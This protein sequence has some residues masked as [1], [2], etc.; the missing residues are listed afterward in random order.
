MTV[1]ELSRCY[2][3]CVIVDNMTD[4]PALP[5]D[6]TRAQLIDVAA[7]LLAEGGA[8]AVTTRAVAEAA[9]TQAPTIYRLF[10][11]KVGLLEA[12]VADGFARYVSDKRVDPDDDPVEGLR[13]G[14]DLHVGFGLANPELFRLMYIGLRSSAGRESLEAGRRVLQERV[15]RIAAAGRLRVSEARAVDLIGAAGSGVVF[16]LIDQ[17]EAD[18]DP[19]LAEAAWQGVCAVILTDASSPAESGPAAAAVTLRAALPDLDGFSAGEREL[20]GEWL[21]RVAD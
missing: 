9:G 10:G 17:P 18:R 15:R 14:W 4:A 13:A 3:T 5:R 11:D 20:L 16:T 7:G 8:G 21:G 12:V 2:Q 1:A 6:R 19:G